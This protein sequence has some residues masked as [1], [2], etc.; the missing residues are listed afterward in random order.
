[1]RRRPL[2]DLIGGGTT[3]AALGAT[4]ALSAKIIE[5]HGFGCVYIGSYAT[6]ASRFGLPDTGLLSLP[7]LV[8]QARTI[9]NAVGVPVIADA[10]GG[11]QDAA[12]LWRTVQ[13]YEQAGVAAIHIEDHAFGKHAA[14]AQKL[15][16]AAEAAAR[17][18]AAV[19]ARQNPD[20]LIVARCDA[21][22]VSRDVEDTI[23]RLKLYTDAGADMVFPT[24][25]GPA[26]LAEVRRRVGKPAMIVDMPGRS[27]AEHKDASIVLYYAFAALVQFDALNRALA[28]FKTHGSVP[29]GV[30]QF[31]KLLGYADFAARARKY[32][33]S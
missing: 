28:A 2:R 16:P 25:V 11:F 22:W 20:F 8:E 17:I 23:A 30:E 1:M 19:D 33:E 24:L 18:R 21:F 7:E 10:E 15:R 14:V 31:E 4:D 5:S 26:E 3:L 12:N 29:G 32:G 9:V 27:F 6:A 13:A